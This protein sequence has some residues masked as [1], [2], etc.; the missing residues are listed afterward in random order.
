MNGPYSFPEITLLITH[1]NRSSSL[2]RLLQTFRQLDCRFGEII[3]SDDASK[4]ENLEKVQKML[5]VYNFRLITTPVNKGHGHS[6]NKGQDEVKTPYTLYVQEDFVPSAIFP[7]H[8]QDALQFMNEDESLDYIRFWAFLTSYPI[9]KP[10]GKGYSEMKYSF[11]NM[12]HLK[13]YQYSDT[14]HLRRSNF[15]EKFGRY[16]EGLKGD[17]IDY[18]M[19]I[20][21][22]QHKG[23]GLF[24]DEY[25]TLFAHENSPDE[26]STMRELTNWRQSRNIFIRLLRLLYL[27]YKW[28]KCTLDVKFMR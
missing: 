22:L 6:I 24:Y 13:F 1:Y 16:R 15:F 23:K 8:L 9:L 17:V 19:A 4:P 11:W 2:E 20:S 10:Y 12:N 7:A 26:P 5:P 28:I 18:K 27:R 21:F 3:V 25:T 14:P